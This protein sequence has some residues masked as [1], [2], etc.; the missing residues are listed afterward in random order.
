MWLNARAGV[1]FE[2]KGY[3]CQLTKIKR[4]NVAN[5]HKIVTLVLIC[6]WMLISG[7]S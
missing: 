3:P 4:A 1:S 6:T 7:E 2:G 5:R